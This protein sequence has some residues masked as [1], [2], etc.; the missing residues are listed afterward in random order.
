M[1]DEPSAYS[2][3]RKW[4]DAIR[5][6]NIHLAGLGGCHP[7]GESITFGINPENTITPN[8]KLWAFRR[9]REEPGAGNCLGVGFFDEQNREIPNI[10]LEWLSVEWGT[11]S[12]GCEGI[13]VIGGAEAA[14]FG[15]L[16]RFSGMINGPEGIRESDKGCSTTE[17]GGGNEA[18]W[19]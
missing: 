2:G 4:A 19:D 5:P 9:G 1:A 12:I 8:I 16:R 18:V 14:F 15:P 6:Y 11:R 13:G 7:M 3:H 10:A 17:P